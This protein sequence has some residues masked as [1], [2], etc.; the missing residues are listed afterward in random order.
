MQ[1]LWLVLGLVCYVG[2]GE[3]FGAERASAGAVAMDDPTSAS[4]FIA[5]FEDGASEWFRAYGAAIAEATGSAEAKIVALR[6]ALGWALDSRRAAG[7]IWGAM[8]A[9]ERRIAFAVCVRFLDEE[10]LRLEAR[11]ELLLSRRRLAEQLR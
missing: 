6:R 1:R 7:A 11:R 2:S 4:V 8:S 10:T 3:T 9:D 5:C